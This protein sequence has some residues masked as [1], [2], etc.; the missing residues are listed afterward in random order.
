M[1]ALEYPEKIRGV[2]RI[3]SNPIVPDK[4]YPLFFSRFASDLDLGPPAGPAVLHG[5]A[6]QVDPNLSHHR[7][8]PNHLGQIAYFPQNLA[9]GRLCLD[10]ADDLPD[11]PIEINFSDPHLRL[12]HP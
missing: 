12:G 8:V 1:Q 9:A 2:L 7:L 10:I 6:D 5:V 3:K 4:E 11:E